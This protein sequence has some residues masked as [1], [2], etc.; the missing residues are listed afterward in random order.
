MPL[1]IGLEIDPNHRVAEHQ[2]RSLHGRVNCERRPDVI[3]LA[4]ILGGPPCGYLRT[5]K[6][7]RRNRPRERFGTHLDPFPKVRN[8][9]VF[10]VLSGGRDAR[11]SVHR[12]AVRSPGYRAEKVGSRLAVARAVV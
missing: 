7:E 2:L 4:C 11:E 10:C 3:V 12:R 6:I 9:D 8:G 5:R 1:L